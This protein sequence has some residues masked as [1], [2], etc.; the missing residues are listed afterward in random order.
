ME[1]VN[2]HKILL[3]VA[4]DGTEYCGWQIQSNSLS[5]Q[6]VLERKLSQIYA[7]T[8]RKSE[9]SS[10]TDAGVHAFSH[11]V[12]FITPEKP[13]IDLKTLYK[14]LNRMLPASIRIREMK[15]VPE[16]FHARFS[17][18]SKAYTYVI[19]TG[20]PSPFTARWN[21][22]LH[23]F[24][25]IREVRK[26]T[27]CLEGKHDFSAF[28]VERKKIDDAVRTIHK[29]SVKKSGDFF[30]ITFIGDG[31]LYKMVRSIVGSLAA[32]GMGKAPPSKIKDILES[33]N[34]VEGYDTAPAKGL[35]LMDVF[36]KKNE[37]KKFKLRNLPF[38]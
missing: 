27:K 38:Q 23:D 30:C 29:I 13:K 37:W 8:K 35:F 5:L 26:A 6:E 7:G 17:A 21:W 16:S 28:T 24:K 9:S 1:M 2:K 10:R 12:S 33:R 34:R 20:I 36:Y 14:A 31:F 3:R 32:V 4:Y 22:H 11:A 18:D 19:N 25:K 15:K